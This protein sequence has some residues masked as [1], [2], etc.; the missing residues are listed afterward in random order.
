MKKIKL[1]YDSII[2]PK[3]SSDKKQRKNVNSLQYLNK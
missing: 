1:F 3:L 2:Y